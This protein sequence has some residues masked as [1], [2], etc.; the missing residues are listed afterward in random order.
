M[1][2][3]EKCKR[4]FNEHNI[5]PDKYNLHF[6]I[7]EIS[8]KRRLSNILKKLNPRKAPLIKSKS[9]NGWKLLKIKN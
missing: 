5:K 6:R 8:T 3:Y 7:I 1:L 9:K 4:Y 2:L